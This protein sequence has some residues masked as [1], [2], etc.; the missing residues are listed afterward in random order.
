MDGPTPVIFPPSSFH[1]SSGL[2][3]NGTLNYESNIGSNSHNSHTDNIALLPSVAAIPVIANNGAPV[4]T[5]AT[6][7][8][9]A[10]PTVGNK[11]V[12]CVAG[13]PTYNNLPL[14]PPPSATND[15]GNFG[16]LQS[17]ESPRRQGRFGHHSDN[18]DSVSSSSS[19]F[20]SSSSS[21]SGRRHKSSSSSYSKRKHSHSFWRSLQHAHVV[22]NAMAT[23]R[24]VS[25]QVHNAAH[26]DVKDQTRDAMGLKKKHKKTKKLHELKR[27]VKQTKS[28]LK[29]SVNNMW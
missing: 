28:K 23:V 2:G 24:S 9:N 15:H 20:S 22:T 4:Y 3:N 17:G 1:H 21:S 5:T 6:G 11:P 27:A 16:Y 29:K 25:E 26:Y 14:N 12:P 18:D 10:T 8:K 7:F 13:Q 19:F